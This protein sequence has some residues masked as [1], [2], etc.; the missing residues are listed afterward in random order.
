MKKS[1]FLSRLF[2][3][4]FVLLII[5]FLLAFIA[6]FIINANS[7]SE[8]NVTISNIP[9][10]ITLPDTA[11]EK[12]YQIFSDTEFTASVEVSGNRVSV[13]SLTPSDIQVTANQVSTIDHADEYT[14]PLS[15]KKAG[16]KSNYNIISS[17]SPSSVTVFVDKFKEKDLP[18]DKSAMKVVID[19]GYYSEVTMSNDT[20]HIEGAASKVDEIESVVI[21]DTVNADKNSP[22]TLQETLVFLDKNSEEIEL[23]YVT[24]D[25]KSIEV[26]VTSQP[27]KD[28]Y[29]ALDVQ[30]AP[31]NAPAVALSPSRVTIYGPAD[32]INS[33]EGDT[34]T[35]GTMDYSTLTNRKYQIPY[36]ISMPEGLKDCHVQTEGGDSVIATIDLSAYKSTTVTVDIKLNL[37]TENYSAE[38]ASST[39]VKL[40]IYGPAS[41]VSKIME[42]NISVIADITQMEE[43]LDSEQTVSINVP[44]TITLGDAFKTCWVYRTDPVNV[45]VSPKK[46]TAA[47]AS[48]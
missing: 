21:K 43:Q 27:K 20:V 45:N 26:T 37:D 17:V 13:G 46:A 4:N 18:I 25:L 11:L 10:Q 8:L 33:I 29:L 40:T 44:L 14:L 1:S 36:D 24:S 19:N 16:V 2:S 28:V 5:S 48:E 39:T 31:S 6:W 15:A 3:H 23:E 38:I 34:I 22:I 47:T 32:Q 9:V 7:E 12:G 42:K 41:V 30:N 35:I